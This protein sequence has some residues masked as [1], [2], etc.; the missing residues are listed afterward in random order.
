MADTPVE[1]EK[2]VL[3]EPEDD[4]SLDEEEQALLEQLAKLRK[5]KSKPT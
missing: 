2:E 3:N 4:D 5:R 1:Q